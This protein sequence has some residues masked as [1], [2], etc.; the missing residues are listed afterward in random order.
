MHPSFFWVR[1]CVLQRI[2]F[3]RVP[4]S[5]SFSHFPNRFFSYPLTSGMFLYHSNSLHLFFPHDLIS[6]WFLLYIFVCLVD[7]EGLI[8]SLFGSGENNLD[9]V[10]LWKLFAENLYVITILDSLPA[11]K[12]IGYLIDEANT[13]YYHCYVFSILHFPCFIAAKQIVW[14][15]P[16]FI[17]L[18]TFDSGCKFQIIYYLAWH[19]EFL[20]DHFVLT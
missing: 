2:S 12:K 1:I 10:S 6:I 11:G 8:W 20:V 4:K 5:L 19:F 13:I 9:P 3:F 7:F 18:L 17:L 14:S 16:L 15:G